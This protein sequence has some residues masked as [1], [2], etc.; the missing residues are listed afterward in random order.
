MGGVVKSVINSLLPTLSFLLLLIDKLSPS[1]VH[2]FSA[3]GAGA[4]T[5]LGTTPFFTIKTRLQVDYPF[6]F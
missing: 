4:I 5:N 6:P 3:V 2:M 1:I